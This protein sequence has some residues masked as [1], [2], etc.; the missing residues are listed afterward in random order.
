MQFRR[1][2]CLNSDSSWVGGWIP[3]S[4]RERGQGFSG[5]KNKGT[6]ESGS[7][8]CQRVSRDSLLSGTSVPHRTSVPSVTHPHFPPAT[9]NMDW[10]LIQ[11]TPRYASECERVGC[12]YERT[13][14]L[15]GTC[16]RLARSLSNARG[17]AW[18]LPGTLGLE[19]PGPGPVWGACA[20]GACAYGVC[21]PR[22]RV[23]RSSCARRIALPLGVRVSAV[24]VAWP[25]HGGT[26]APCVCVCADDAII[27]G[28]PCCSVMA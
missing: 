22:W 7:G 6:G 13:L 26:R 24:D 2:M 14:S 9:C 18:R 3:H 5:E 23:C 4:R 20:H 27:E 21:V 12:T 17:C 10:V 11:F 8:E 15:P 28:S 19:C 1:G 16:L 25:G